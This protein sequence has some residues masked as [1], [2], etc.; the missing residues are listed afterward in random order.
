LDE[1]RP[2]DLDFLNRLKSDQR[3]EVR[4]SGPVESTR[5]LQEPDIQALTDSEVELVTVPS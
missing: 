5:R 3:A 4:V 1:P 2:P